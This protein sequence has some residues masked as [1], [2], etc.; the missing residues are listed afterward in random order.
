MKRKL[1]IA[2]TVIGA[3]LALGP[4]WGTVGAT[5]A[6]RRSFTILAR[7]SA[8]VPSAASWSSSAANYFEI[9]L[10]ACPVGLAL[11]I[12]CI[13]KLQALYRRPP[14]LPSTAQGPSA[15]KE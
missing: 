13:F 12:I 4:L 10:I 3:I 2:G 7:T 5:V 9:G 11:L 1:V 14:P 8:G 15:S 6:I